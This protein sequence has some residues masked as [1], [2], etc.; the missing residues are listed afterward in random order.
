M[1]M[2][3][4]RLPVL[5]LCIA[6]LAC[7]ANVQSREHMLAAAGF[8]VVPANTPQRQASL[9]SLPPHKFVR[10]AH[11][12]KVNYTYA[13]PT[14]CDCLYAGNEAAYGRYRQDMTRRQIAIEQP[15]AAE[16]TEEQDWKLWG[17]GPGAASGP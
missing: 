3:G 9:T 1:P 8:T 11:G 17:L 6:V 13:D 2:F 16:I 15:T 10:Q 14:V 7:A 4:Q 5:S 12:D